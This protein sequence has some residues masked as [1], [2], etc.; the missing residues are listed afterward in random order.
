MNARARAAL[1]PLT[2]LLACKACGVCGVTDAKGEA[3]GEQRCVERV[4]C[5]QV[6]RAWCKSRGEN[7]SH[8]RERTLSALSSA[9]ALEEFS[10]RLEQILSGYE[11]T[12]DDYCKHLHGVGMHT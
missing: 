5:E 4:A 12:Q 6:P 1:S 2:T 7:A 8:A 11:L 3:N 9:K 10:Q